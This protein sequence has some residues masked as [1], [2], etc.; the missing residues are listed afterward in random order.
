MIEDLVVQIESRFAELGGQLTD[1]EVI[2]DR[3]RRLLGELT[4]RLSD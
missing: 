3:E 2:S 1:P 4:T